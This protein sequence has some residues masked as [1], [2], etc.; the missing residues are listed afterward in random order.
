M[1]HFLLK[2]SV[3]L[4]M[5]VF[6]INSASAIKTVKADTLFLSEEVINIE[7][8]SDFS[9]I[10]KDRTGDPQYHDGELIYH[11]PEGKEIKLSVKVMARGNFRR[12]PK[13]CSFPPLLLNFKKSEVKK[14]L[15]DNQDKLK[16]VTPC[17]Y[18]RYVIDE[19]LVYKMY[20]IITEKSFKVRLV[21]IV[22]FD[23]AKG[24]KLFEK[25]S[26]FIEHDEQ[27][28]ERNNSVEIDTMMTPYSLERESF[29]KIAVFQYMV[30]NKDWYVT[31][32]RNVVLMQPNDSTQPPYAIPYDFDFSAFIDADY[33]KP[34]DVPDEYLATRRVYKGLCYTT[35]EY[36]E[37]FAF[38]KS[39][40]PVFE[41]TIDN[42]PMI[43]KSDKIAHH[44]Y[45][46]TF[47]KTIESSELIKQEFIDK[48]ETRKMYNL[49]EK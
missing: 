19:Y 43:S 33:T 15:F 40:R 49:P 37:V 4:L 38:F 30:G 11:T 22:Y 16:L 47:Y 1:K 14:T 32:R 12:D 39:L 42:M 5:S 21:N 2:L 23:T 6:V 8:R 44:A 24:K 27:V 20:N 48:C 13:N 7:L 17:D 3:S 9:A 29:R 34:K 36:N 41:A 46:N 31:S 26:F 25:Y 35:A 10:Q 45:L 18:D 28:A